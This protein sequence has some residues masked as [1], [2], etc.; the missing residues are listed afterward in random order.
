[1][2]GEKGAWQRGQMAS[3]THRRLVRIGA[4]SAAPGHRV[5]V[6][7][8]GRWEDREGHDTESSRPATQT[9]ARPSDAQTGRPRFWWLV[10]D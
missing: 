1:M 3:D 2:S 8:L 5:G 7:G 6:G 4:Q 9:G 10:A